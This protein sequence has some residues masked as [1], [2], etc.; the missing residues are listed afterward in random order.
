MRTRFSPHFGAKVVTAN[1]DLS[2]LIIESIRSSVGILGLNSGRV[3]PSFGSGF[4]HLLIKL[5]CIA[6]EF[7][8]L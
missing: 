7:I 5:F 4:L 8:N 3:S 1:Y 6:G 2:A